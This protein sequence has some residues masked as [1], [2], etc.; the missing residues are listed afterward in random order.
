M[1]ILWPITSSLINFWDLICDYLS[2]CFSIT[3]QRLIVH[4]IFHQVDCRLLADQVR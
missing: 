3:N 4:Q 2:D 1:H